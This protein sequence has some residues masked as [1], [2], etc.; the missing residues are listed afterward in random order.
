MD[1]SGRSLTVEDAGPPP[2]SALQAMQSALRHRLKDPDSAIVNIVGQPKA[3]V[4][5]Q[6]PMM[7]NGGAGWGICAEVNAKN[8]YGGY[9]GYKRYFILWS[10][11][12]VLDFLDEMADLACQ[13]VTGR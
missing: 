10:N 13:R 7:F 11:G 1:A 4:V 6:V 3:M 2:A 8:S 9:V 12:Q 5:N